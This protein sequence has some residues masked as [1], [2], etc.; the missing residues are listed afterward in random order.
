MEQLHDSVTM[1]NMVSAV[2][3][4]ADSACRK[5]DVG[6]R[7]EGRRTEQVTSDGHETHEKDYVDK[8]RRGRLLCLAKQ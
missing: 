2:V 8:W 5:F 4:S 7:S 1:G 3:S 6:V